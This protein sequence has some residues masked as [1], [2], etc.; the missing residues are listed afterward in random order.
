MVIQLIQCHLL[1]KFPFLSSTKLFCQ[2]INLLL[3]MYGY[4]WTL[5]SAPVIYMS[6]CQYQCILI[7]VALIISLEIRK[8]KST[9]I[10]F[11][12]YIVFFLGHSYFHIHFRISVSISIKKPAGILLNNTIYIGNSKLFSNLTYLYNLCM[13]I[14]PFI[15]SYIPS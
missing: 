15:H 10:L 4:F 3:Y 14:N 2:E 12:Y 9:L 13:Q 7:S 5:Y 1:K 11:K 6:F 8:C